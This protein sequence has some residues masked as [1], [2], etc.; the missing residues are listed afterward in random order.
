MQFQN[1]QNDWISYFFSKLRSVS[2]RSEV[3]NQLTLCAEGDSGYLIGHCAEGP[4]R[5]LANGEPNL[6][7]PPQGVK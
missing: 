6:R 2:Y 3:L 4:R 7:Q 1:L 5:P